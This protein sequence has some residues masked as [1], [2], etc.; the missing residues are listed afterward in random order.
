V[1]LSRLQYAFE[2]GVTSGWL[3]RNPGLVAIPAT[4]AL[5][6]AL[7]IRTTAAQAAE[8]GTSPYL[9]GYKDFLSGILPPEPGVYL[10]DDLIFYEGNVGTTIIGGRVQANLHQWFLSDVASPTV[11]TSYKIFG[12]TYAFG[13]TIPLIGINVHAGLDTLRFGSLSGS[14]SAVNIGDIYFTPAIIGWRYGDFFWN[15][16]LSIVTPTG[17]Y[18][19][20]DLANTGLNYW[21]VLP[22]F[23]LTYFNPRNGWDVSGAVA[24]TI[25][26]EN[27]DTN[28]QTGGIFDLDWA[29]GK[30][31]SPH[32]KLGVTGYLL[33]QVTADRGSGARLG[34]NE[35]STWALGP[36]VQYGFILG[37]T[38]VSALL[39]WTH[40]ISATNTFLGNTVTTALS[41]KF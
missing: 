34:S 18:N 37:K 14:D 31:I 39:K 32:W 26:T 35:A 8:D 40:E 13:A 21:T 23:A 2:L 16:A 1:S 9:K 15:V 6:V 12:G 22:Q 29:V 5:L 30:Q 3:P 38:P 24:Y 7:G 36:A 41:F 28:Y 4:I 11:V 25:N 10:R 17:K 20:D 19:S 33:E 27:T